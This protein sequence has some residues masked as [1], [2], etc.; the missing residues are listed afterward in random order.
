[1]SKARLEANDA[2]WFWQDKSAAPGNDYVYEFKICDNTLNLCHWSEMQTYIQFY[3]DP[4]YS[5]THN[6]LPNYVQVQWGCDGAI[7]NAYYLI[8]KSLTKGGGVVK[9]WKTPAPNIPN[10]DCRL[11]K[12]DIDVQLDGTYYYSIYFINAQGDRSIIKENIE[13]KY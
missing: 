3:P 11:P 2:K 9:S 1:M 12:E 5:V 7:P 4:K 8:T 13:V 10:G 6:Y